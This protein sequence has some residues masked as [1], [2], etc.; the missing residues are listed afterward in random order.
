M[1]PYFAHASILLAASFF[2]YWLLLRKETF[3][4]VNRL[5]LL[6][7]I[8]LSALIP[9]VDMP[10]VLSFHEVI[11]EPMTRADEFV[12]ESRLATNS[13]VIEAEE[14]ITPTVNLTTAEDVIQADNSEVSF[15][16]T[17]K[18]KWTLSQILWGLY[19]TGVLVF[20]F[21]FFIQFAI[22]FFKK[23][24]LE[25]MQDGKY[26]IYELTDNS[27]PFS[28]LTWI[29]INPTLYDYDTFEQIIEHEKIHVSQAHYIDKMLAEL[30]VIVYWFNPFVWFHRDSIANN[31]EF[32]TDEEMLTK[33]TER[34]SYQMSLL[35]VSVPEH[36][37]NLT[38]NYNESFLSE[39]IRM[40]NA[41]KSSAKSSWKYLLIF[42]LIGFSMA[43]LN[44]VR[45][46]LAKE[47][48]RSEQS[49]SD[50]NTTEQNKETKITTIT[51]T[52]T[53]TDNDEV[54]ENNQHIQEQIGAKK[55]LGN[56]ADETGITNS[57]VE[58]NNTSELELE[59]DYNGDINLLM[60]ELEQ[61]GMSKQLEKEYG[62]EW[63]Q[64]FAE[65]LEENIAQ[66]IDNATNNSEQFKQSF[67][68]N[69]SCT[70]KSSACTPNKKDCKD[71]SNK[72]TCTTTTATTTWGKDW[73]RSEVEPGHWR[74]IVK[75][76]KVCFYLDN[77]DP[78]NS[79][80]WT[81]NECFA[82]NEMKGFSPNGDS[83]FNIERDAGMLKMDGIFS[84]GK[85]LGT[86]EFVENQSFT[87]F[88]RDEGIN[89][90]SDKDLFHFFL[91]KTDKAYVKNLIKSGYSISSKDLM[92]LGI[93]QVSSKK[94]EE[95]NRIFNRIGKA[96]S[97]KKMIEFSIHN[98][99]EAFVQNL[100]RVKSSDISHQK[101][102]TAKIHG[103][104]EKNIDDLKKYGYD[105]IELQE[106]IKM[107]I[108]G[109]IDN[110]EGFNNKGQ[111]TYSPREMNNF[112]IHGI[113]PSYINELGTLGYTNVSAHDLKQFG[114][115]GVTTK[116]IKQFQEIG[117]DN[118]SPKDLIDSKIHG[119]NPRFVKEITDLGYEDLSM[120]DYVNF[121]IHGVDSNYIYALQKTG[122]TNL[123]AKDLKNG[124]IHGINANYIKELK[125]EGI[126][127]PSFDEL[128]KA[129]IQGVNGSF[130][131]RAR[132]KGHNH[133][134]LQPYT[135]L[136][137]RGLSY[138]FRRIYDIQTSY[139]FRD[140]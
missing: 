63:G 72:K 43:T 61:V 20:A 1:I 64:Q 114:I 37:L 101:I 104:T 33:G 68:Q 13:S 79:M 90:V 45:P 108:H 56:A 70:T 97:C 2:L 31:L 118:L 110:L 29:F 98:V 4:K 54:V 127:N 131:R 53:T 42:P 60:N 88:L 84:N 24:K 89:G 91:N 93:H 66:V 8:V 125:S 135:K 19:F 96:G 34:E 30:A 5:F 73:D 100:L 78:K 10:A 75:G 102:V 51:S 77:S 48:Y 38:T 52:T 92:N 80:M 123:S 6:M 3:F 122:L 117:F 58:E 36:S 47:A 94:L 119:V 65:N 44:A 12:P 55:E 129:K 26:R 28:F 7:A 83:K 40:M 109:S 134:T 35:K 138:L 82:I 136:K 116:D 46:S 86:F 105:E 25:Y 121:M 130:I 139:I 112:S 107:K 71:K 133:S 59:S 128:K 126:K 11:E 103:V 106:I 95:Y 16:Q 39:R 27:P 85:G 111:T 69:N 50:T 23:S 140:A 137:I 17:L 115:H 22:L 15:L 81:V 49:E 113:T 76:D 87:T 132:S 120:K 99:D 18:N 67:Q 62:K 74:G 124:R 14:N 32:L 9:L 57:A 41:K 21:T